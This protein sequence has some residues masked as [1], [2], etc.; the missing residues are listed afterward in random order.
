MTVYKTGFV[1]L[2]LLA[3]L[4]FLQ[5]FAALAGQDTNTRQVGDYTIYYDVLPTDF[6]NPQVA[7]A[8]GVTRSKGQGLLRI[9]V[10]KQQEEGQPEPVR[11]MASGQVGN[12]VGQTHGLS[13]R[14]VE[15]GRDDG[16]ST[17]ATFRYSHDEPLRFN[18]RVNYAPG[19]PAEELH[20]IRRLSME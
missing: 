6:L 19:Q 9:T 1:N 3:S 7:Q 18:L 17:L 14:Q 11:A 12:L 20:F 16:Y 2:W 8:Y 15:V 10:L 4:L 13:F 5:S